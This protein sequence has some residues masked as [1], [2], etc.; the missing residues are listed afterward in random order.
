[1]TYQDVRYNLLNLIVV[2]AGVFLLFIPSAVADPA[3]KMG[4][5]PHKALYEIKLSSKKS[6]A[7]VANISG[8]MFYEWQ[9]SC[10]AWLS[11]HKFDM[12][13]EYIEVPTVRVVSTFSTVEGFDGNSFNFTSQKKQGEAIIQELRGSVQRPSPSSKSEAVYTMPKELSFSLSGGT[14][15][16]IAHSMDVMR[17]IKNGEK[18]FSDDSFDGSDEDG[19]VQINAFVLKKVDYLNPKKMVGAINEDLLK[20]DQWKL[21]LSFFPLASEGEVADY[22]MSLV[23]HENGV[24]RDFV[25]DY[26]NFSVTQKLVALEELPG[27][28]DAE[29]SKEKRDLKK[30]EDLNEN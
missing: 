14:M 13:Y 15:F 29:S 2:F 1:M 24:M 16:P 22:E 27:V 20:G 6:S 11:N 8:T 10:D 19:P 21:R 9:P 12:T 17:R 4:F 7:K 5:V 18:F 23:F 28:C 3:T 30:S 25:V 26:D